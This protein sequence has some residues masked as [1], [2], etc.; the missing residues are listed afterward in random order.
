MSRQATLRNLRSRLSWEERLAHYLAVFEQ[1]LVLLGEDK[2]PPTE[3]RELNRRLWFKLLIVCRKLDPGGRFGRPVREAENLPDSKSD[4]T[5]TH[6]RKEPDFQWQ[7]DDLEESDPTDAMRSFAI[8]CK[9]L[10]KPVKGRNLNKEYVTEGV[11]RFRH[12][13]WKYGDK[14]SVGAMIGYVQ[15]SDHDRIHAEI[16]EALRREEIEALVPSDPRWREGAISKLAH[17]FEREFPVSPFCLTHFW[18]DLRNRKNVG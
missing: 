7:Y 16:N 6:E 2:K 17:S 18:L 14:L 3:E 4:T 10:G 5:R 1:A 9:R 15:A 13:G 12:P 8:E 11:V